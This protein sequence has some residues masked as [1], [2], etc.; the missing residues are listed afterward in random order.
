MVAAG[1][2]CAGTAAGD[3]ASA[4]AAVPAV[5]ENWAYFS[6]GT[7]SLIG[8]EVT[9]P[10][11]DD[12]T[13]EHDFTN[14]GGVEGTIRLLKNV[15]GLWLVQ[16]C[17]L[18]WQR[19]GTELSYSQLAEMAAQAQPFSAYLDPNDLRFL[20]PGDMPERINEYLRATGQSPVT[21]KA[22][23]IRVVLEGLALRARWVVE[24]LEQITGRKLE[25]I[26][27]VGGGIRNE[28]LCQFVA[29]ATGR[30]VIA[31]PVEATACGN[32]LMQA[33]ATGQI[34]S[35]ARVRELVRNSFK[36]RTFIRH[37]TALWDEHYER[38]QSL[39]GVSR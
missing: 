14:E 15:M 12:K 39:Y 35:L 18:A 3:T 31:G 20:A 4:V 19:Q 38:M 9:R 6:C 13:F 1:L 10:Y 32:I 11:I 24:K 21:D 28:L 30:R 36:L 5:G 17:R 37:D 23:M 33:M 26:Y 27:M 16:Q 29:D 25:V 7:W 2:R 8:A 22:V 34:E